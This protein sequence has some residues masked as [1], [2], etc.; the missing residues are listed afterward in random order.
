[1]MRLF[2]CEARRPMRSIVSLCEQSGYRR[3]VQKELIRT[4]FSRI[5]LFFINIGVSLH[6][7]CERNE[8]RGQ[9][10]PSFS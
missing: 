2:L 5:I 7:K 1:M 4:I 10:V 9:S 3:F 6:L 8:M